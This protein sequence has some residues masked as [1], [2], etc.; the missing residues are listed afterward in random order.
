VDQPKHDYPDQRDMRR[1][2]ALPVSMKV[3]GLLRDQADGRVRVD[4]D[5]LAL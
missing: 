4:E 5:A 2:G 1:W 3:M